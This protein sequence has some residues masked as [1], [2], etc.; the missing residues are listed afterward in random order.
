[1]VQIK[2]RSGL[3]QPSDWITFD[4]N[5]SQFRSKVIQISELQRIRVMVQIPMRLLSTI[6]CHQHWSLRGGLQ[7]LTLWSFAVSLSPCFYSIYFLKLEFPLSGGPAYERAIVEW[8]GR[9]R[10][11]SKTG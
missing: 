3:A 11:S 4:L 9:I 10:A 6:I 1:M 7:Y 2:R 8:S 5:H